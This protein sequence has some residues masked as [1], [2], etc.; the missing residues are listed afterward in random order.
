MTRW[1]PP[2]S[3]PRRAAASRSRSNVAAGAALP[4]RRGAAAGPRRGGRG[5]CRR[6][7]ARRLRASPR[8]I[9]STPPGSA[10]PRRRCAS[11]SAGAAMP[12]PRSARPRWWSITR[13]APRPWC[14]RSSPAGARRFGQV[15]VEGRPLF[16]AGHIETIAR[17]R[18]GE[19]YRAERIEDLRQ[20]LVATGLVSTVTIR[21]VARAGHRPRR[22]RRR[23]RAGADAHHRRRGRLRHRRGRAGRS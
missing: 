3:T 19:P 15:I 20:A 6:R 17:F 5:G 8:R 11:S 22:P 21:P 16:S 13:P 12:S 14:C 7:F 2:R 23:A 9:R 1:S 18:E 10:R 4:L